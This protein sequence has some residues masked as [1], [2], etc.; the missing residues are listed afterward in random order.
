MNLI[1]QYQPL[2]HHNARHLGERFN[3][4][5]RDLQQEGNLMLWQIQETGMLGDNAK[6]VSAYV[7]LRVV[8]AMKNYIA[9]NLG[10]VAVPASAFWEKGEYATAYE[11]VDEVEHY[12]E[13]S[14]NSKERT[15]KQA[16]VF[17]TNEVLNPEDEY[18]A[19]EGAMEF[20]KQV[21]ALKALLTPKEI[22]V[23]DGILMA[24]EPRTTREMADAIG[25]NSPQ[26]VVNI[27]DRILEKARGIFNDF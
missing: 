8:G 15:D 6:A 16:Y 19:K 26:T 14:G 4:D 10:P 20:N 3:M 24:E 21:K 25:V 5:K 18:L 22:A 9:K 11:A 12:D 27:R 23:F 7:K 1:E 2:V 17:D 13:F